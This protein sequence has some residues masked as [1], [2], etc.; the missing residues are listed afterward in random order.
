ML[1]HEKLKKTLAELQDL[2]E[3]ATLLVEGKKDKAALQSLGINGDFFLLGS[4]KQ[5]LQESAEKLAK[6]QKTVILLLDADKKGRELTKE[7]ITYL[8]KCGAKVD[9][10]I[11]SILLKLADSRTI[12]GIKNK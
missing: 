1:N 3:D 4:Q 12:E 10:K 11:G 9:R 8:Q 6:K 7:M 5:S 2:A